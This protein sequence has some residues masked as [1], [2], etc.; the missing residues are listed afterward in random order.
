MN[1]K[2]IA[3]LCAVM[4][5]VSMAFADLASFLASG[6]D[7]ATAL[8]NEVMTVMA[9]DPNLSADDAKDIASQNLVAA[10]M[11]AGASPSAAAATAI[12]AGAT[13]SVAY[14]AADVPAPS[15]PA[16][17]AP[18]APAAPEQNAGNAGSTPAGGEIG[19]GQEDEVEDN[20]YGEPA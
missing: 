12:D 3:I 6:A 1:K 14:A 18:A 7:A 9:A 15:A 11:A 13:E 20:S 8:A 16:A 10:L 5:P 19:S 4:L 17:S 2:L